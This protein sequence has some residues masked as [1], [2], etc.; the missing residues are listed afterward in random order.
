MPDIS[1]HA[2]LVE[3][4]KNDYQSL[5]STIIFTAFPKEELDS[6]YV[7]WTRYPET[8]RRIERLQAVAS[9]GRL[10][11][12]E[13]KQLLRELKDLREKVDPINSQII[14]FTQQARLKKSDLKPAADKI[15]EAYRG[16]LQQSQVIALGE[17]IV[18]TA[19]V[20]LD[21]QEMRKRIAQGAW[22]ELLNLSTYAKINYAADTEGLV[23]T[24]NEL[25]EQ[26]VELISSLTRKPWGKRQ[27]NK[28][29]KIYQ[30][31]RKHMNNLECDSEMLS[32][33]KL[34]WDR[35]SGEIHE[36]KSAIDI[37]N[38]TEFVL[39]GLYDLGAFEWDP[40]ES[41]VEEGEEEEE[42]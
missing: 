23:T 25:E 19:D 8:K 13:N 24:Q 29:R 4:A 7:W 5:G 1:L 18:E 27:I 41:E 33:L 14:H 16:A 42:T 15:E 32:N 38:A 2:K 12:L 10:P 40:E 3:A 36:G 11:Y 9:S 35:A 20:G 37:L 21:Q 26:K 34:I 31:L 28:N 22:Q 39:Q 6:I 30:A 17:A